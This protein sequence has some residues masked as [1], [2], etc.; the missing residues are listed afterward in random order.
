MFAK[1]NGLEWSDLTGSKTTIDNKVMKDTVVGKLGNGVEITTKQLRQGKMNYD[2]LPDFKNLSDQK[3]YR[4]VIKNLKK[5]SLEEAYLERNGIRVADEEVIASVQKTKDNLAL[6][7][8][9]QKGVQGLIEALGVDEETYWKEIKFQEERR[10]LIH[11]TVKGNASKDEIEAIRIDASDISDFG[12]LDM[13]FEDLS[14][15]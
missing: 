2:I 12:V 4:E 5:S 14:K 15:E 1:N 9:A 13:E 11:E 3:K 6:D 10:F 8:E 7:E